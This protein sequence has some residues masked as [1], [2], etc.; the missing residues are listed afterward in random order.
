MFLRDGGRACVMRLIIFSSR[1]SDAIRAAMQFRKFDDFNERRNAAAD[2]R[3]ALVDKFKARPKPDDPAEIER[4]AKLKAIADAREARIQAR[5][6]ER[7]AARK[8]EEA[9]IEAE[10]RAREIAEANRAAEEA[11]RQAE[12]AARAAEE[13][14]RARSE[15]VDKNT[16]ARLLDEEKKQRALALIAEQRAQRE[17]REAAKK[18][19]KKK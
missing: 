12:T 4:Q 2:A 14:A 18:L 9:R 10:R 19:A 15:A 8:A 13:A 5:I 1:G 16:R 11:R 3:K 6:A 7:E 17:A